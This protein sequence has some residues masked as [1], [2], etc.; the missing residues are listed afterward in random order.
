MLLAVVLLAGCGSASDPICEQTGDPTEQLPLPSDMADRIDDAVTSG[1]AEMDAVGISLAMQCQQSPTYEVGYG[2]A[3]IATDLPADAKTV[4]EI[5]SITKQFVAYEILQLEAAGALGLQDTVGQHLPWLPADWQVVTIGELL[6][7]TGGIPDHFA[8]FAADPATPFNWTRSYSATEIVGA[9]LDVEDALEAP[10]GTEFIYSSTGYAVLAA[11]I[12]TLTGEPFEDAMLREVFAPAGL[13]D[14]RLCWDDLDG[15]ATGYNIEPDG[16]VPGPELPAGWL[17][18]G[19]G[20]CGTV[21]DLVRWQQHLM[22]H[23]FYT[24]M[25]TPATLADGT[26]LP[27]GLGL[28]LDGIGGR[29]A[30]FHEGG[31]V[32]FSS[33]LAHYPDSG[34]TVAVLS[35]TLSPNLLAILDL[36]IDLTDALLEED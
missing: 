20:I 25:N 5:G 35:N 18:G 14:T 31:T 4:Y 27:Y 7:H 16:P 3:D 10:P 29:R 2:S 22:D 30:V 8:I 32:S 1:M 11:V 36:V 21:G 15:L 17:S 6:S 9:F 13:D 28:H 24:V 34:L 12:E 26:E 19:A 23:E 33:W